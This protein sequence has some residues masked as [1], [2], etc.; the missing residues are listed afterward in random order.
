MNNKIQF[1]SS[2]KRLRKTSVQEEIRLLKSNLEQL[3]FRDS[4]TGLHNRISFFNILENNKNRDIGI[5]ICDVNGLKNINDSLGIQKGDSILVDVANI[6]KNAFNES[7]VVAR[8]GGDEFGVA[9]LESSGKETLESSQLVFNIIKK[10]NAD[11]GHEKA[12]SISVGYSFTKAIGERNIERLF[13]EAENSLYR[14]KLHLS[15]S[16]RSAGILATKKILEARDSNTEVHANRSSKLMIQLGIKLGLSAGQI[17]DLCLLGQFHDIGKVAIPDRILLKEGPLDQE[18]REEMKRHSEIGY[19]IALSTPDLA[20]IAPF[21][22]KHHE[23]WNGKGYPTGLQGKAIPLECRILAVVDA[24]DAM[25]NDRPYRKAMSHEQAKAELLRFA[26]IQFDPLVVDLFLS[27][28][29][30]YKK[31]DYIEYYI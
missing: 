14:R 21:I 1:P 20:P 24:Y 23:W 8:I 18:E 31:V 17:A 28:F 15:Q 22:L 16:A 19:N 7:I 26:G 2:Q 3:R 10:Y 4:L 30:E 5:I 9:I 13:R 29:T 12:I 11:V 6:L 25:T 27:C